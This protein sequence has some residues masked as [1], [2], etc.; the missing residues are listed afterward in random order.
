M[1]LILS[2]NCLQHLRLWV[3]MAYMVHKDCKGTQ[4]HELQTRNG[5][6]HGKFHRSGASRSRQLVDILWAHHF[7]QEQGYDIDVSL[8]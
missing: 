7:M 8:L 4:G 5:D 1:S 6:K 2:V 3:D